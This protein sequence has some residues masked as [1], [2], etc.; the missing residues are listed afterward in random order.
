VTASRSTQPD[1]RRAATG[2]ED[3]NV[4]IWDAR[5]GAAKK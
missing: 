2:G 4:L 3:G 1:G 5:A